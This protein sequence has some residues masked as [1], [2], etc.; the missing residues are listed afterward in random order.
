MLTLVTAPSEFAVNPY[1]VKEQLR[2]DPHPQDDALIGRYIDV[3]IAR[4]D[5]RDGLLGRCLITQTWKSTFGFFPSQ[6]VVP[7]PPCQ[8]I[9]DIKYIDPDDSE[10]TLPTADFQ[11]F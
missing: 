11:V 10:I 1:R 2:L 4:L 5:G 3:A 7:L 6:I 8:S 9:V